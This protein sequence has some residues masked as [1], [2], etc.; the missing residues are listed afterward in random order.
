MR[1]PHAAEEVDQLGLGCATRQSSYA[2]L[3]FDRDGRSGMLS[4]VL[5]DCLRTN[6]RRPVRR[7]RVPPNN[8]TL[9]FLKLSDRNLQAFLVRL[10]YQSHHLHRRFQTLNRRVQAQVRRLSS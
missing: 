5:D 6:F 4:Y 7:L 2:L 9:L 10:V 1:S 3:V 8:Q